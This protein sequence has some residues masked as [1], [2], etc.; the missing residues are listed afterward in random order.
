[1]SSMQ[2]PQ[3]VDLTMPVHLLSRTEEDGMV[4][5]TYIV[6]GFEIIGYTEPTIAIKMS[7]AAF[8]NTR[9]RS[10]AM[11]IRQRLL[12][13]IGEAFQ[14]TGK[15]TVYE[16]PVDPEDEDDGHSDE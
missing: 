9:P 16:R 1:M 14:K 5:L 11:H 15:V 13:A 12:A 8:S 7:V 6:R 10:I 4:T 3:E 2:V